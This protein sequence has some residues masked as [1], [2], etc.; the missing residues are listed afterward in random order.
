MAKCWDLEAKL[1]TNSVC[2][3]N[4]FIVYPHLAHIAFSDISDKFIDSVTNLGC[5]LAKYCGHVI[6]EGLAT[7]SQC[8]AHPSSLSSMPWG[9]GHLLAPIQCALEYFTC[10]FRLVG[11]H[12]LIQKLS[13]IYWTSLRIMSDKFRYFID[14]I[15]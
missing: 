6:S 9:S 15:D 13:V 8:A 2:D 7:S 10:N 12:V 3:P 14:R 5:C 11:M 1:L 4:M